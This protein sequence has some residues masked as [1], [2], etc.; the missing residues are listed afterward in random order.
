MAGTVLQINTATIELDS[1]QDVVVTSIEADDDGNYI[2]EFRFFG[3]TD[4]G[5]TIAPLTLTVRVVAATR[6]AIE[7]TTPAL[8][9]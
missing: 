1:V 5:I 8:Q 3:A 9:M 4:P 2:R 7:V 6:E